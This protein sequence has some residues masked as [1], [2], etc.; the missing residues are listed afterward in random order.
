[1]RSNLRVPPTTEPGPITTRE[2]SSDQNQ[3]WNQLVSFST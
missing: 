3:I 2:V 1:L